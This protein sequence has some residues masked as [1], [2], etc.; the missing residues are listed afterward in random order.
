MAPEISNPTAFHFA[1]LVF[2]KPIEQL[3]NAPKGESMR[4][5]QPDG[6]QLE[7]VLLGEPTLLA[8]HRGIE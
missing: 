3:T 1:E 8:G 6:D 2:I 7:P 5:Q 4:L